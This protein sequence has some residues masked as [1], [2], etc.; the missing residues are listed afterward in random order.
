MAAVTIND[1]RKYFEFKTAANFAA[2][3]RKLTDQDKADIKAGLENGT[4]TY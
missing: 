2:E 4:L 1:V 3:W